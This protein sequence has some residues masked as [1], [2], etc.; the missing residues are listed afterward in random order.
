MCVHYVNNSAGGHK[1][2]Y[3]VKKAGQ[4]GGYEIVTAES[5]EAMSREQ[6]LEVR[7]KK[8]ADRYCY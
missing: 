8:K 2:T 3:R 1:V 7:S 5:A 6:L 4:Y